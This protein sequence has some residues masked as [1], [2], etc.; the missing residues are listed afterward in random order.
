MGRTPITPLAGGGGSTTQMW[1]ERYWSPDS[2][3]L[4]LVVNDILLVAPRDGRGA[5]LDLPRLPGSV[6]P[7]DT[8]TN[9]WTPANQLSLVAFPG[10]GQPQ[11]W[12]GTVSRGSVDWSDPHPIDGTPLMIATD[13]KTREELNSLAPPRTLNATKKSAD[14]SARV[15]VLSAG[16]QAWGGLA[17]EVSLVVEASSGRSVVDL[18]VVGRGTGWTTDVVVVNGWKGKPNERL[19][20]ATPIPP[21][22]RFTLTPVAAGALAT[23]APSRVACPLSLASR[24]ARPAAGD[25]ASRLPRR[26]RDRRLHEA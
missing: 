10:S 14:G 24:G 4:A 7:V 21:L 13:P 2:K 12:L 1:S 20:A 22:A 9:G 26:D 19:D 17:G 25:G 8:R 15:S 18:G 16:L 3:F 5:Q 11:E 6:G 23:P